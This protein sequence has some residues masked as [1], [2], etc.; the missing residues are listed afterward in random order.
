MVNIDKNNPF[1]VK[2][3]P[4]INELAKEPRGSRSNRDRYNRFMC[5]FQPKTLATSILQQMSKEHP[6]YAEMFTPD[7]V[8]ELIAPLMDN[9]LA[10]T[11]AQRSYEIT[12]QGEPPYQNNLSKL[13][14]WGSQDQPDPDELRIFDVPHM[15]ESFSHALSQAGES[16]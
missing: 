10:Q 4:I 11:S 3:G 13:M 7:S 15:M 8:Y 12:G 14:Q 2:Q 6:E 9:M 1:A 5:A 16:T